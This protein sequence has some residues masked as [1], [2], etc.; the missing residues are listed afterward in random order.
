MDEYKGETKSL[1]VVGIPA[2]LFHEFKTKAAKRRVTIKMV[3]MDWMEKFVAEDNPGDDVKKKTY[4][5]EEETERV[6]EI[7]ENILKSR[8]AQEALKKSREEP[9]DESLEVHTVEKLDEIR[10]VKESA[11]ELV[12]E[13]VKVV[14]A[15]NNPG[16]EKEEKTVGEKFNKFLSK[17]LPPW[18]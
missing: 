15:E 14:A 18:Y 5:P 13:P 9:V 16:P 17:I 10:T 3:V 4:N 7:A 6:K 2:V 1:N 11:K 12:K 8:E